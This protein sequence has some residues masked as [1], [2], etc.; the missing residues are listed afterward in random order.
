[1]SPEGYKADSM[2]R[3]ISSSCGTETGDELLVGVC[4][5]MVEAKML[6][7]DGA[8]DGFV[9]VVVDSLVSGALS[10]ASLRLARTP[11]RSPV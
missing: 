3:F 10:L 9:G 4:L 6:N 1:M 8:A 2:S 11:R 5:N 7:R